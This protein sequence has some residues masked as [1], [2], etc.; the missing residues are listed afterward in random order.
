MRKPL[1]HYNKERAT[2]P[3]RTWIIICMP[4]YAGDIGTIKQESQG[5]GSFWCLRI[6]P[7]PRSGRA[8]RPADPSRHDGGRVCCLSAARRGTGS[9]YHRLVGWNQP[10]DELIP[11]D[12]DVTGG[13]RRAVLDE[14]NSGISWDEL[15]VCVYFDNVR[16]Q[17][18]STTA[19]VLYARACVSVSLHTGQG[20][21]EC[22]RERGLVIHTPPHLIRR[23]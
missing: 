20:C 1:A 2:K 22:K 19:A 15:C 13:G 7:A 23:W 18:R 8:K 4:R 5:R 12:N 11:G 14:R 17:M 21:D 6:A 10:V 3:H 16:V 9:N